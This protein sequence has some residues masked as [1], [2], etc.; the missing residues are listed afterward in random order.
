[1][2][3]LTLGSIFFRRGRE[4]RNSAKFKSRETVPDQNL[5]TRKAKAN[6]LLDR[7]AEQRGVA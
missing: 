3:I 2:E 7:V 6:A 1:L 5:R 4:N